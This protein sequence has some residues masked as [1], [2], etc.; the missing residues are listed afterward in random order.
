MLVE[1]GNILIPTFLSIF[2][3]VF[4]KILRSNSFE[5]PNQLLISQFKVSHNKERQS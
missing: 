2:M 4:M 5:H 1:H 3:I